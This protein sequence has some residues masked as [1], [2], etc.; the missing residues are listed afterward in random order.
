[1]A[2]VVFVVVEEEEEVKLKWT[3]IGAPAAVHVP[4]MAFCTTGNYNRVQDQAWSNLVYR[5]ESSNVLLYM[6]GT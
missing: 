2:V 5:M 6:G 1:M 4:C 3:Y